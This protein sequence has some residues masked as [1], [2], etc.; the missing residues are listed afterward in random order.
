MLIFVFA[1][2]VSSLQV[3]SWNVRF[4]NSTCFGSGLENWS[5]IEFIRNADN[6]ARSRNNNGKKDK[7]ANSFYETKSF[8]ALFASESRKPESW[9]N[10]PKSA[11]RQIGENILSY[12]K[13]IEREGR[14]LRR[15]GRG[16][17]TWTRIKEKRTWR[18]NKCKKLRRKKRFVQDLSCRKLNVGFTCIRRWVLLGKVGENISDCRYQWFFNNEDY[19][20]DQ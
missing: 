20:H 15:I 18:G 17:R 14:N 13:W 9:K 6:N 16:K 7:P 8:T 19:F 11:A 10:V 12:K 3:A 4:S 1:L 5:W 2:K